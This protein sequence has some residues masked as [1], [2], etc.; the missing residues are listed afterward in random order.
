MGARCVPCPS[1]SS[2]ILEFSVQ[3]P[4]SQYLGPSLEKHQAP[5]R[6]P[7]AQASKEELTDFLLLSNLG[8]WEDKMV[9]LTK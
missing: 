5:V 7:L 3:G 9:S 1:F 2:A 6:C 4:G 8:S